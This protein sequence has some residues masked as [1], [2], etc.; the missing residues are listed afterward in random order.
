[1]LIGG[2]FGPISRPRIFLA[3]VELE[4]RDRGA[5]IDRDF[6]PENDRGRSACRYSR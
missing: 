1:M 6:T 2:G 4:S 3:L 5:R